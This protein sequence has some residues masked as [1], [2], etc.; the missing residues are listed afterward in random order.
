[1]GWFAPAIVYPLYSSGD[2]KALYWLLA[3]GIFYSLGTFFTALKAPNLATLFGTYL[4][5]LGVFVIIFQLVIM[6][7]ELV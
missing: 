2:V 6:F 4:L 1:M 3:G 5:L 7:I